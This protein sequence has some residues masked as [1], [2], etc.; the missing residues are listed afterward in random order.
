MIT[1][2]GLN[3]LYLVPG[4]VGG[5]EV[6]ARELVSALATEA[7]GTE[8]IV[9]CG[10]EAQLSLAQAGWPENVR[11]VAVKLPSA[12]KPLRILV[13]LF[14]LPRLAKRE[15][16]QLLHSLGTTAPL[17]SHCPRVVTIHD[18]IYHHFPD[19]FPRLARAGLEFIVPRS[20][21][22]SQRIHADSLATKNDLIATY[23][24]PAEKIDVIYLGLGMAQPSVVTSESELRTRFELGDGD[25]VLS[26]AAALAHKNI[27]RL[28]DAFAA[29]LKSH[30]GSQPPPTLVIAGHAGLEQEQLIAHADRLGIGSS[31]R[32]TGWVESGDIEG[33]YAIAS[34]FV[35]PSMFE[36]FGMP[37]LEAMQRGT[38]VASSNATSLAEVAGDGAELFDPLDCDK[39]SAAIER[40]LLDR[41]YREALI[42]RGHTQAAKFTWQKTARETLASYA[43]VLQSRS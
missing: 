10:S 3:L 9:F 7:P 1:R 29:V 40:L 16:V 34:C 6:F 28:L 30:I 24:L 12:L 41:P 21:R 18:L 25:V 37:V 33:L 19:T 31:V 22:R 14:W 20:A 15:R 43:A 27:G 13:E 38:P 2:V 32:F 8:F 39:M 4:K 23:S 11:V 42:A 26:V 17:W 5:T 35:Y 36:G